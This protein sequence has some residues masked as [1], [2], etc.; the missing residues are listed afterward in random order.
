VVSSIL[1]PPTGRVV[2]FWGVGVDECTGSSM[3]DVFVLGIEL[4][5]GDCAELDSAGV[6]GASFESRG[7]VGESTRS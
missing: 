3:V 7:I 4:L 5:W 2:S 6:G 1:T